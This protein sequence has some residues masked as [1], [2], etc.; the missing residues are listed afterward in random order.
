MSTYDK[1]F[2]IMLDGDIEVCSPKVWPFRTLDTTLDDARNRT[3]FEGNWD[4]V[5]RT[6]Y[7]VVLIEPKSLYDHRGLVFQGGIYRVDRS[8]RRKPS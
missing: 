3:Q 1:R 8:A 5:P 7:E 2:V 6:T 4:P